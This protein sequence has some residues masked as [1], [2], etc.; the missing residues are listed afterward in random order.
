[1]YEGPPVR[2]RQVEVRGTV[3][4][5]PHVVLPGFLGTEMTQDLLLYVDERRAAFRPATIYGRHSEK[6]RLDL[7]ARNCLRLADMGP[8]KL[9][10][11]RAVERVLPDAIAA[12]GILGVHAKIREIEMCAYGDATLFGPHIDTLKTGP[13][14][15]VSCVYYFFHEPRGF[16]GGELRFHGWQSLSPAKEPEWMTIDVEPQCD[17]LTIFPSWLRHEV[18][19]IV[20]P[21]G[22]WRDYRFAINCWGY[23]PTSQARTS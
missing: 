9:L 15:I 10:I 5:C 20:C 16:S 8:F 6:A 13:Q 2:T 7:R 12:L 19:P 23:R 3:E 14:R 17:S 18:R 1:M 4:R 21:S 11:K 22:T